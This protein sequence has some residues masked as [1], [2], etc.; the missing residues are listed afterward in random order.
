MVVFDV[1]SKKLPLIFVCSCHTQRD[2][3]VT[4]SG[5]PEKRTGHVRDA[6]GTR[7][8]H[9]RDRDRYLERN[10]TLIKNLKTF[11]WFILSII[12]VI[13]AKKNIP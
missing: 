12:C 11:F 7:P 13:L 3:D 6:F 10:R 9:F 1:N 8:G 5:H 4:S 2:R